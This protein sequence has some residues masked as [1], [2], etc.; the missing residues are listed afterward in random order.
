MIKCF[1]VLN[2]FSSNKEKKNSLWPPLSIQTVDNKQKI[3]TVYNFKYQQFKY[4]YYNF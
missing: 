1:P 3:Y 4:K 2:Y